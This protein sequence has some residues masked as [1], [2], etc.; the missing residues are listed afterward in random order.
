M[1][2]Q[3]S[4]HPSPLISYFFTILLQLSLEILLSPPFFSA[5]VVVAFVLLSPLCS[6]SFGASF[7]SGR[8]ASVV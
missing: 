3:S 7:L 6:L 2:S 8:F 4:F 5:V 1:F